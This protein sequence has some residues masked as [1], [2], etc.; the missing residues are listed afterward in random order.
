MFEGLRVEETED[1]FENPETFGTADSPC[2]ETPNTASPTKKTTKAKRPKV[3]WTEED[4]RAH[5][6]A[7]QMKPVQTL[8]VGASRVLVRRHQTRHNVSAPRLRQYIT[9]TQHNNCRSGDTLRARGRSE[10]RP[11]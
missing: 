2:L 9:E 7:R 5:K 4:F 3:P 10:K 6:T 11:S 1:E 8:S